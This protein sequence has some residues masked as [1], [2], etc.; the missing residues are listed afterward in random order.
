MIMLERYRF[1]LRQL[2]A[3]IDEKEFVRIDAQKVE[4]A[5]RVQIQRKGPKVFLIFTH[6]LPIFFCFFFFL[7][8]RCRSSQRNMSH[9]TQLGIQMPYADNSTKPASNSFPHTG[10]NGVYFF[11]YK[12]GHSFE[13]CRRSLFLKV[14][15]SVQ[16]DERNR[17]KKRE[18]SVF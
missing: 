3:V 14:F 4:S 10:L 7:S 8:G 13:P 16:V 6:R 11:S 2:K 17:Q 9:C 1:Q 18:E 5:S 12:E 15:S